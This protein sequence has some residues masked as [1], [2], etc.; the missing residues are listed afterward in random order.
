MR[1]TVT[2]SSG[3]R[4][5]DT[6]EVEVGSADPTASFTVSPNPASPGTSVTVD[7]SA[8]TTVGGATIAT[9]FWKFG[10]TDATPLTALCPGSGVC[11]GASTTVVYAPPVVPVTFTITLTVT[12]DA[13]P[14]RADSVNE[15]VTIE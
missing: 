5:S 8:S 7:A 2:D 13:T 6:V 10:S 9:Y 11:S 4:A 3:A 12:D 15:T 1:L 14:P